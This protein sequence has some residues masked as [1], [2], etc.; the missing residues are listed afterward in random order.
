MLARSRL[1]K[2]QQQNNGAVIVAD[3][4][5]LDLEA[6]VITSRTEQPIRM[7]VGCVQ[8]EVREGVISKLCNYIYKHFFLA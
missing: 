2:L 1:K 6:K 7:C 8:R 5:V 4:Q 3:S